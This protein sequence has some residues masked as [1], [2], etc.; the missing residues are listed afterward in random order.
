MGAQVA[1]AAAEVEVQEFQPQ[2]G[3]RIETDPKAA[4]AG[5]TAASGDDEAVLARLATQLRVHAP[6]PHE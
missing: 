5:P 4:A 6:V 1:A 2:T 3:V